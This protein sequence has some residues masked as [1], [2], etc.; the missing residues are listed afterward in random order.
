MLLEPEEPYDPPPGRP[1]IESAF[2]ELQVIVNGSPA[3]GVGLLTLAVHVGFCDVCEAVHEDA[4]AVRVSGPTM[5][6]VSIARIAWNCLTADSVRA[7]KY[8][9]ALSDASNPWSARNR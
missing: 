9:V 8:P 2:F 1:V 5:P 6:V 7:P 3:F 4:I